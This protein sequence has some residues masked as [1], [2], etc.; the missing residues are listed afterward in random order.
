MMRV[1]TTC[2]EFRLAIHQTPGNLEDMIL[3]GMEGE[4]R[5]NWIV[6]H[7]GNGLNAYKL[8]FKCSIMNLH[9]L[10]DGSYGASNSDAFDIE[11]ETL[12]PCPFCN[13]WKVNKLKLIYN[14][15][16]GA[17]VIVRK[18]CNQMFSRIFLYNYNTKHLPIQIKY[19]LYLQHWKPTNKWMYE[20]INCMQI[21][22][23]LQFIFRGF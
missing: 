15:R 12:K 20:Y 2:V 7:D 19:S 1:L 9:T 11:M 5:P 23:Y 16:S 3:D 14:C 18:Q 17:S 6:A 22:T 13:W 21:F 8:T 10:G 4:G